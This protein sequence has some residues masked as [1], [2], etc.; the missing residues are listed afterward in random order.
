MNA[1][2]TTAPATSGTAD[3]AGPA[4]ELRHVSKTYGSGAIRVDALHDLSLTLAEVLTAV[5]G[6]SGSGKSTFLHCAAGLD[7]PTGGSVRL[8]GV[9]LGG[10]TRTPSRGSAV[11]GSDSSSSPST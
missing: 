5:M 6:A 7:R 11:S 2:A 8:G 1:T 10:S 3:A 9:D 4:L